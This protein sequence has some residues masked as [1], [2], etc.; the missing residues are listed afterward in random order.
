MILDLSQVFVFEQF[1]VETTFRFTAASPTARA[2]VVARSN[3][4]CTW[5]ATDAPETALVKRMCR[6]FMIHNISLNIALRPIE[7]RIDFQEC[8][9]LQFQDLSVS[10]IRGLLTAACAW[11]WSKS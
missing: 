7:K 1:G 5:C 3:G 6:Q 2:I 8:L 9:I 11:R 10:A 4:Y